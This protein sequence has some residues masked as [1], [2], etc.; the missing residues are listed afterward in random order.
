MPQLVMGTLGAKQ[1]QVSDEME[2]VL[3]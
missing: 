3:G 1:E 2:Y